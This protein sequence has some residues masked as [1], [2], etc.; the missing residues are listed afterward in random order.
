MN[1]ESNK[2]RKA[3]SLH[4]SGDAVFDIYQTLK[5]TGDESSYDETKTD[6]T[7]DFN[8][9]QKDCHRLIRNLKYSTSDK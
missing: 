9:H 4:Y 2:R 7:N 5:N 8:K 1:I 6:P 3:L